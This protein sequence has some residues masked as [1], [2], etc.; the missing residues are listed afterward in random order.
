[1][2]KKSDSTELLKGLGEDTLGVHSFE[3]NKITSGDDAEELYKISLT[4]G[5]N[6]IGEINTVNQQCKPPSDD[7]E[8]IQFCAINKFETIARTNG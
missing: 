8:N 7:E 5:T 1:M 3:V 6:R 4:I 2:I